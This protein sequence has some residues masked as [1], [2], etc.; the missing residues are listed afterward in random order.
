MRRLTG[1]VLV[2]DE[3]GREQTLNVFTRY[4]SIA[5]RVDPNAE[6]V[7]G[8]DLETADGKPVNRYRKGQYAITAT[9]TK[10]YSDAPDAP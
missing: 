10:L 6:V 4:V 8:Y 5:N 9:G 2:R 3:S 7:D 1:T